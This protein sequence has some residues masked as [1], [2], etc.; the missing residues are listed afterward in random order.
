MLVV[1]APQ[2]NIVSAAEQAIEAGAAVRASDNGRYPIVLDAS[3]CTLR[4]KTFLADRLPVL[5]LVEFAHD[6]LL[7]RL[8]LQRKTDPV[9][10]HL[11]CSARRM[12]FESKLKALAARADEI[13]RRSTMTVKEATADTQK[14][15]TKTLL[16]SCGVPVPEGREVEPTQYWQRRIVDGD[17]VE[18]AA[19]IEVDRKSVV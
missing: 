9:L 11:N 14:D 13:A 6:A 17:V 18:A 3:A 1:N 5:D 15:L 12:G 2:S 10:I 4:M 16:S 19:V 8:M 7:P